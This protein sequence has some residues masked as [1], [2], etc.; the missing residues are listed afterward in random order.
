MNVLQFPCGIGGRNDSR[1]PH[2]GQRTDHSDLDECLMQ[3]SLQ[4][5]EQFQR[6]LF[7]LMLYSLC[8]KN[9]L[10]ES[11]RLQLRGKT[12]AMN[13]A[14]G[15]NQR[16]VLS[17]A[18]GRRLGNRCAGANVSGMHLDA[19]DATAKDL[20]HTNEAAKK[21]RGKGEA[22]QHHFGM[23]SVFLT[24][25]FDDENSLILN[26]LAG[27]EDDGLLS[28][29]LS[30]GELCKRAKRRKELRLGLPGMAALNFEMLLETL[31]E[32]VIG[33]DCKKNG[34]KMRKVGK[35]DVRV[36]GLVTCTH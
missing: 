20:P 22:M 19:V 16:D 23:G 1:L 7:Q 30:D 35:N 36:E 18:N 32:E 5:Q 33:W 11:S 34:P 26:V 27:E 4:S 8:S 31:M 24:C 25:T 14:S 12:D 10:L 15:S 9:K 3:L 17:C 29:E 6:P 13:L 28:S 2:N 21:A